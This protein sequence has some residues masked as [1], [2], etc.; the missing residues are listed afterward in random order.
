M[1]RLVTRDTHNHIDEPEYIQAE[2]PE[3]RELSFNK[4]GE[5]AFLLVVKAFYDMTLQ[6][7]RNIH[8]KYSVPEAEQK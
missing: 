7:A 8:E 3:R 1:N 6:K 4:N 2:E 5:G